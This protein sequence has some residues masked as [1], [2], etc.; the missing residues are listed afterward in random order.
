MAEV[1]F[2]SF[3]HGCFVNANSSDAVPIMS[4]PSPPSSLLCSCSCASP[5]R[6]LPVNLLASRVRLPST[7][8]SLVTVM[9][10]RMDD[11]TSISPTSRPKIYLT[12]PS[13]ATDVSHENATSSR[14]SMSE[15][16]HVMHNPPIPCHHILMPQRPARWTAKQNTYS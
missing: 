10:R 15:G 16:I 7:V 11:C 4:S 8:R 2:R 1:W 13:H 14:P 6:Q 5:V 12:P 3:I 9:K